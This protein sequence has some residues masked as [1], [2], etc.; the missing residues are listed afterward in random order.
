MEDSGSQPRRVLVTAF[1][2]V[3][4]GGS[5]GGAGWSLLWAAAS[6]HDVTAVVQEEEIPEIQEGLRGGACR[7]VR[8]IGVGWPRLLR[9]WRG[10]RGIGHLGYLLWHLRAAIV[11]RRVAGEVEV[12]HHLTYGIDWLPSGVFALREV[13]VVWGPVGG[14]APFRLGNLRYMSPLGVVQ[15]L[16]REAMSRPLRAILVRP[17]VRRR[18]DL[19]VACNSEVAA[20]FEVGNMVVEESQAALESLEPGEGAA[21]REVARD[22]R[23]A[24]FVGRLES[25][26]GPLLALDA[27]ARLGDGWRLELFGEGRE[28]GAIRR[29]AAKLGLAERVTL[30]G[31]CP[32]REVRSAMR[33][34]D[35]L[36]FPSFH[37]A[38]GFVVAEAIQVGCPVVCLD[39]GGPA[40]LV[41]DGGGVAVPVGRRL[42]ERLAA[43]VREAERGPFSD[44]WDM[45]RLPDRLTE[46]YDLACDTARSDL[47]ASDAPR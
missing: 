37:D 26:K 47:P 32:R 25:W 2:C 16:L 7:P 3:P 24:I 45:T 1:T 20:G 11:A 35:V 5:E 40:M 6:R 28:A 8:L 44:R 34:A 41:S 33:R 23:T 14:T 36:L 9:R 4:G 18:C 42:P 19:V 30:H 21:I 39:V 13:P 10:R 31:R 43:A 22:G 17:I 27:L 12:A 15:E 29:R 46:W 38:G